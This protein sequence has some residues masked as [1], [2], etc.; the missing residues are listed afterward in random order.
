LIFLSGF[1]RTD[2]WGY[3]D[4]EPNRCLISSLA[5][6]L[7]KTGIRHPTKPGESA[8]VDQNEMAT[9]QKLL[10]FWRKPAVRYPSL[11]CSPFHS[12]RRSR[13]NSSADPSN[14]PT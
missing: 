7:L 12:V 8:T 2:E 9:A 5:L 11:S 3:R 4:V 13:P 10:L 1:D 6:V 14:S